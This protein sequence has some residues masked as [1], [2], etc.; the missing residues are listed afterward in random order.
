MQKQAIASILMQQLYRPTG[1]VPSSRWE[2]HVR[3]TYHTRTE[4]LSL[5][6]MPGRKTSMGKAVVL[7]CAAARGAR[8]DP[9]PHNDPHLP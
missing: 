8:R 3:S 7:L 9:G 5:Q 2:L 4:A 6:S 1:S